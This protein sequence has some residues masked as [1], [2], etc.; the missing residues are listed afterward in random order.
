MPTMPKLVAAV[1]FAAMAYLAAELFKPAEPPGTQFGQFSLICAAIGAISGWRVMGRKT[2]LG[3]GT[4]V[5]T[6]IQTAATFVFFALLLFCIY[7]MVIESIHMRYDGPIEAV[8]GVFSLMLKHGQLM[9]TQS[10]LGV[11]LA[12]GVLG[13]VITEWASR[14]WS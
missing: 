3:Y 13:G 7:L 1:L 9:L 14:R 5:S 2:G 6:G 10:V 4:A 11:L 12:G 8:L